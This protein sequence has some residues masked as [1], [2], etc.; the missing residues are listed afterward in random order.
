MAHAGKSQLT[1]RA[2]FPPFFARLP[3]CGPYLRESA[4]LKQARSAP[5]RLDSM[6]SLLDDQP[7]A[8]RPHQFVQPG[9]W[10][11]GG[12]TRDRGQT[13]MSIRR[14]ITV[15]AMVVMTT[16]MAPA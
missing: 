9:V 12:E 8:L 13:G 11:L 1:A 15:L 14:S 4:V 2:A 16:V 7:A 6:G 3:A 10:D 5:T